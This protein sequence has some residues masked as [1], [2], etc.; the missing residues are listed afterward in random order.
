MNTNSSRHI[1]I[2]ALDTLFF[3]DGKPFSMGDETWAEGVFPPPPSVIYGS[4]RSAYMAGH[5][6]T[7][8]L[9]KLILNTESLEIDGIYLTKDENISLPLPLDLF[10]PGK[11]VPAQFMM[12]LNQEQ[13]GIKSNA[14][15][16]S[17][18]YAD[19]DKKTETT[20]GKYVTVAEFEKYA[21]GRTNNNQFS[22]FSQKSIRKEELKI[23]I[24]RNRDTRT[25]AEGRLYR[26][27]MQRTENENGERLGLA[28]SFR[29]LDLAEKGI[30][31]LGGERKAVHFKS[32][33]F[34]IPTC[35][36]ISGRIFKIYLATAAIFP[37][38]EGWNPG[39]F[40]KHNGLELVA[41]SVGKPVHLGGFSIEK[42][43]VGPKP[44]RKAVPAGS[45]Y[46]VHAPSDMDI[47]NFV[48]NNVHGKSICP[49]EFAQQ[50]LGLAFV[51]NLHPDQLKNFKTK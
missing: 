39:E 19:T 1:Q 12:L 4:L 32:K 23:G 47:D 43:K 45:V 5:L 8:T 10:I 24:A 18:L 6:A 49:K 20:E 21:S 36:S 34:S 38:E 46:Y 22:F 35:P 33:S 28:V 29:N 40:L 11:N 48:K 30:L 31:Q 2:Q 9:Q 25:A 7:T 16:T 3:R 44:M 14:P 26:I 41:S 27:S 42:G 51:A 50:G 13:Q 17:L 15:T 37:K